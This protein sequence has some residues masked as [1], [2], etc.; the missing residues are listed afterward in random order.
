MEARRPG[1]AR[2]SGIA[3]L[4]LGALMIIN[5]FAGRWPGHPG[6]K[7]RIQPFVLAQLDRFDG[8]WWAPTGWYHQETA[9]GVVIVALF[10]IQNRA[11]QP[12][13][14]PTLDQRS[15]SD[16]LQDFEAG[17]ITVRSA[18]QTGGASATTQAIVQSILGAEAE[19][20]GDVTAA[21][22]HLD[23]DETGQ[24]AARVVAA[25]KMPQRAIV[26][27]AKPLEAPPPST[28]DLPTP[29]P[30]AVSE[31]APMLDLPLPEPV[32]AAPTPA[33]SAPAPAAAIPLP[34]MPDL[35]Q[36]STTS[37]DLAADLDGLLDGLDDLF[38]APPEDAPQ[39]PT[40][41]GMGDLLDSLDDLF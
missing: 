26:R 30:E 20:E 24:E 21:I 7:F 31:S 23:A 13:P 40:D 37:S 34:T 10:I 15:I 38:D 16:Q 28:V 3:A 41:N 6:M 8:T 36:D 29:E 2:V 14:V 25:A 17:G 4:L 27:E 19:A 32:E 35:D 39:R 9:V 11:S 1:L 22:A 5:A 18:P 12:R 33:P